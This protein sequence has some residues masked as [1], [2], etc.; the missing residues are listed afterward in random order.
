MYCFVL[1]FTRD[2]TDGL[3]SGVDVF[4]FAIVTGLFLAITLVNPRTAYR[5]HLD[6]ADNGLFEWA[7][8]SF[9]QALFHVVSGDIWFSFDFRANTLRAITGWSDGSPR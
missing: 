9:Q 5:R 3:S 2:V 8:T 1:S 6:P 4:W 7:R